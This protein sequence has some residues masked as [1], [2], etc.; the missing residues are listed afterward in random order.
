M[1]NGSDFR[2][3]ASGHAFGLSSSSCT[4]YLPQA[5]HLRVA[6][7]RLLAALGNIRGSGFRGWSC[8]CLGCRAWS[9]DVCAARSY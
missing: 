1:F 7:G 6:E 4:P 9:S 2:F 5:S 8:R 3:P